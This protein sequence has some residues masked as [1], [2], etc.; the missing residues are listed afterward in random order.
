MKNFIIG[1]R[2]LSVSRLVRRGA[3]LADIGTDH[4]YL[5]IY[6]MKQGIIS[7]AYCTD[8]N[9][10]PLKNAEEG[11]REAGLLGSAELILTSGAEGLSRLGIT[12]YA[13]C[14]MG[15]ELIA[16]IISAAPHMKD[17]EVRLLLQPMTKP[18]RLREY[19]WS[20]GFRIAEE[21]YSYEADKYYVAFLAEYIGER[22]EFSPLDA[23]FGKELGHSALWS[24]EKRGYISSRAAALKKI[25]LG[26]AAGGASDKYERE[27]LSA[28]RESYGAE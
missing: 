18:E 14:G 10:G 20:S 28:L 24:A 4:A 3:V 26:K 11:L 15:G 2:L 25:A 23:Y 12:D 8:I 17:P 22:V 6:L 9:R 5:P 13:V 16:E 1:N 19:L 21:C 7:F 27:L